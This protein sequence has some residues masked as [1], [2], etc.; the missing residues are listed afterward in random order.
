MSCS[1]LTWTSYA[2]KITTAYYWRREEQFSEEA[3][4][5]IKAE[6]FKITEVKRFSSSFW[7]SISKVHKA[8]SDRSS[9][10]AA[11]SPFHLLQLCDIFSWQEKNQI[12]VTATW[13]L[14]ECFHIE[15]CVLLTSSSK[16]MK[17]S[18]LLLPSADFRSM[19]TTGHE[20]ELELW[21]RAVK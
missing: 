18:S 16:V 10:L 12:S 2:S 1:R 17:I 19:T 13:L 11:Y 20:T 21:V 3:Y 7:N 15:H 4:P 9:L 8:F 6:N 5:C 14:Q